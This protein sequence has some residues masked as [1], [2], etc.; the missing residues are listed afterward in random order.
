MFFAPLHR[1]ETLLQDLKYALRTLGRSPAFTAAAV[2]A[3]AL[4]VGGSSAMFSVLESVV[5]RPLAAPEPDRLVRLYEVS[6]SDYQGAWSPAD[7]IDLE[8]ENGSFE[9]VAAIRYASASLTT[10]AGPQQLQAVRV[11]AS[12]FAA[13]GVHPAMGRGF[14][15]EDDL[16]GGATVAVLTDALWRR[17]FGADRRIV[18]QSVVLNGRSYTIV[19]VLPPRFS[20]PMLKRAELILPLEL[21]KPQIANRGMHSMSVFGRIRR[22]LSLQQA[23]ADLDVLAPRISG[24]LPEHEGQ[25]FRAQPLLENLVG[26]VKPVLQALLGAVVM[27]L[28]IACANVASMLL[29]RGAARQR[30]LAIRAAL[31]SGRM[32]IVRQLLTESILLGLSGGG[33]GVL[34][35]AWGVDGLV[36]LA[37]R[38]IPRLDEVRL[39]GP[40]LAFALTLSLVSGVLA[41]LVPAIQSSR[42]DVVEALKNGAAAI[43]SRSRARAALVVAEVALALVLAVGAGLMIRTLAHL[44]VV[45]TG[46]SADPQQVLVAETNLPVA[47]YP[48]E[49]M[50]AAFDRRLLE[51]VSALPGVQS[52]ALTTSVPLDSGFQAELSFEI[53]GEP[54]PPP[55]ELPEAEVTWASPGYLETLGIPLLQG[56]GLAPTDTP[57][58]GNVVLVNQA[59]V[60]KHLHGAE[61]LG[62]RLLNLRSNDD[63]GWTI[64]GVIGDVHT[65]ALDQAPKPLVIVHRAQWPLPVVRLMVR[66]SGNPLALVP[67]LR[68]EVQAIDKD[69]PVSSPRTLEKVISESLGERKFQMTLLAAFGTIALLLA[70]V[71]IYGV[72]AYSVA[73]RSREI[74]IRMALG[75][76]GNTVLRMVVGSGL[77]LALVGVGIGLLGAFAVTQALRKALYQVSTTD[78]LT[79]ASVAGLLLAVAA[80]ASWAPALRATRVDP[81]V[82]LRAE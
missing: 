24:R 3:I 23:Q 13:L 7:F 42:P 72:V 35:A 27:V 25:T 59:F 77:R 20:F 71:G 55:S 53:E 21:T 66:T 43:T 74:G 12:F 67:A 82:S 11:S 22:G 30:E 57:T 45:R 38:T 9:A 49:E 80:L 31:G 44:I 33:L 64:V 2:L 16:E 48:K 78:P 1:M 18:G 47:K 37:P 19:G 81:I 46:M 61:A 32:R 50:Y 54:K 63:K 8:K 76:Q 10:D 41:G 52:A 17:E 36:A 40:V 70:S 29:A 15:G 4:G 69:L 56:R 58:S 60:R 68:A 34:L 5:L 73:Q 79:F 28:L 65:Q 75:A 51:R 26:S 39:D 6:R 62:R 14:S